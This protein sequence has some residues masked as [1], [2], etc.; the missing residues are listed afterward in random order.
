MIV[1]GYCGTSIPDLDSRCS[2]CSGKAV[3][4]SNPI[5]ALLSSPQKKGSPDR[6]ADKYTTPKSPF[7][8]SSSPLSLEHRVTLSQSRTSQTQRPGLARTETFDVAL[9]AATDAELARDI[10]SGMKIYLAK[11]D[12]SPLLAGDTLC[13]V[14]YTEAFPIGI[15]HSCQLPI[16]G[17]REEGM[18]GQ[19]ISARGFKWH[20]RCFACSVCNKLPSRQTTPLLLPDGSP[21]C[22]DCY[23]QYFSAN[24]QRESLPSSKSAPAPSTTKYPRPGEISSMPRMSTKPS[25]TTEEFKRLLHT[26]KAKGDVEINPLQAIPQSKTDPGSLAAS[27][28]PATS[29][30]TLTH[31]VNAPFEQSQR[32]KQD[33]MPSRSSQSTSVLDRIRHFDAHAKSIEATPKSQSFS[34]PRKPLHPMGRDNQ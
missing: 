32:M 14:C 18:R 6:W 24:S 10:R 17:D 21:S 2:K 30:D 13:K 28:S 1:C 33:W 3:E 31:N 5:R 27:P 11:N 19:H 25:A 4:R 26:S 22:P 8:V 15:C 29:D 20:A 34:P 12:C 7:A 9:T 16:I 23:E